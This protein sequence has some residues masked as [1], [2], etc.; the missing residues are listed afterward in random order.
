MLNNGFKE[1]PCTIPEYHIV[2]IINIYRVAQKE[3]SAYDQWF[4][5]NEGQNENIVCII[6]YRILFSSKMTPW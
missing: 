3:R 5:K 1:T 2:T 6:A 4:Q